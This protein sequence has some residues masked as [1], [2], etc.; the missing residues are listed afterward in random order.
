MSVFYPIFYSGLAGAAT[1]AGIF[2]VMRRAELA[3]RYS[4]YVNSFAAGIILAIA[5]FHLLPEAMALNR[6]TFLFA[7]IG[8]MVFYVLESFLVI[9]SGAEIHYEQGHLHLERSKGVTLFLGL[10]LHSL[11]DG[12]II[13][14]GFE[15]DYR[16]GLI[17]SA[18]VILHELPEGVTSFS[19]LMNRLSRRAAYYLS[20]AVALATPVG[21]V[22]SILFFRDMPES[23]VGMLLALAGGSFLYI[24]A[25]DLIP[26]THEQQALLNGCFLI[27][28]IL[29]SALLAHLLH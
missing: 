17:T 10:F 5:F 20:V 16:I 13:G 1:L 15:A 11:I 28:G 8:F 12:I 9:H 6:H 23:A 19:M 29:F 7:L 4:H 3:Q 27:G 21:A 22:I 18:A 14:I 25:S 26:E 2:M 24:T